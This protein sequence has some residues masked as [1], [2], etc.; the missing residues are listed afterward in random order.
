MLHLTPLNKIF[1]FKQTKTKWRK[2]K[3]KKKISS[4]RNGD[5]WTNS[6]HWVVTSKNKKKIRKKTFYKMRN[7]SGRK[8][9][10]R[11]SNVAAASAMSLIVHL[12]SDTI[13]VSMYHTESTKFFFCFTCMYYLT[14]SITLPLDRNTSRKKKSKDKDISKVTNG[15]AK[16]ESRKIREWEIRETKFC[17]S[18]F[19]RQNET[20]RK[21]LFWFF[22]EFNDILQRSSE[23]L[24]LFSF[25]FF[26]VIILWFS[27]DV[28]V[29]IFLFSLKLF[30]Q[31]N[32]NEGTEKL[33]KK[34][35]EKKN[36]K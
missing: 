2:I 1:S 31:E 3:K 14:P 11:T 27:I 26:W 10:F 22:A 33:G 4:R 25:S 23:F 28:H 15:A 36:K 32:N 17:V 18:F 20:E 19:S 7:Y 30:E 35:T 16:N 6:A 8:M 29:H 34:E 13:Q 5:E 24:V 21:M 9:H 12:S